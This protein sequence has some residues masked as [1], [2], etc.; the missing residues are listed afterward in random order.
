MEYLDLNVLRYTLDHL[1]D[2]IDPCYSISMAPDSNLRPIHYSTSYCPWSENQRLGALAKEERRF[3][4]E[5]MN[6]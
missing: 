1:V 4:N 2:Y 6:L 5:V 3:V